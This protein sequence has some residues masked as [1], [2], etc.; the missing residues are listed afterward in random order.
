MQFF[1]GFKLFSV[2]FEMPYVLIFNKGNNPVLNFSIF[3][4]IYMQKL[5]NK[6][7]FRALF[8][9]RIYIALLLIIQLVFLYFL[10][11]GGSRLSGAVSV[12]LSLI[13]LLAVLYIVRKHDKGS[14]KLLWVILISVM[15]IFGGFLY[16][17]TRL[18]TSFPNFKE[19]GKLAEKKAKSLLEDS[20]KNLIKAEAMLPNRVHQLRYLHRF[21]GFPVYE[22]SFSEYL[23]PGEEMFKRLLEELEKAEK[24]IF[25]EYFIIREGV[26]WNA[27][28]DILKRKAAAGVLVRVIYDDVGCF[29]TLPSDYPSQ[30]KEMGIECAVFNPFR[31]LLTVVQNNRDH[32]KIASI[33][34]KVVFTGGI[35]ISDEYI[36]EIEKH[37]HWKD[38]A[39]V[40][41]GSAAWSFTVMFLAMWE[42]S[43]GINEDYSKFFPGFET[44]GSKTACGF[45]QPYSDS[46]MD[47]ENVGEHVYLQIISSAK[48][49]VYINTPYLI[50]DDS[51]LSALV[52]AAKSGVDVRIVTPHIWDKRFVHM[53]TR[54]Y[55]SELIAA[56]VHIYEYSKGFIHSK[57]FV[58]DDD[59][60]SV[61][62]TNM[63]YRSLYL[64]FECGAVFYDCSV[65][66]EVKEDFL[67]TLKVCKEIRPEDC[68]VN[69]FMEILQDCL[70]L[71]A[72][73]M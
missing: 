37:G 61:G 25:L 45:V 30:L 10:V 49:Y 43:T 1:V 5:L 50:I 23:S 58:S 11:V 19:N 26:M 52:L 56:G 57:T 65:V 46:P 35:N 73:L 63:D 48:D 32:R 70:R 22:N 15:P 47:D 33:D 53:T 41:K 24:Y 55:Y 4:R 28:L 18:Q 69:F 62:T 68:R 27:V 17:M 64:H 54:S 67:E 12:A 14:Y 60:A 21:A 8:R 9:R 66:K 3:R 40:I 29:F 59:I 7:W 42:V 71:I 20:D 6:K 39:A 72:P 38:C 13:S 2:E 36:N 44:D 51:M 31:P 34:G 16:L